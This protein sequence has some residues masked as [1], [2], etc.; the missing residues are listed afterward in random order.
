MAVAV[1]VRVPIATGLCGV[2]SGVVTVVAW[3]FRMDAATALIISGSQR[4][5][6]RLVLTRF[7]RTLDLDFE[8]STRF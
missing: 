8:Q 5:D 1:C 6:V 4:R 7:A 3:M 2:F